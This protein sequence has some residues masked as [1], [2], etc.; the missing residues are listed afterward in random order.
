MNIQGL[1]PLGLTGLV[2]FLFKELSIVFYSTTIQKLQ[3]LDT[4]P[5]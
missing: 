1:F 3:F 4:Q 2:S 5:F